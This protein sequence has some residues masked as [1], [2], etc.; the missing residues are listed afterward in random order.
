[1]ATIQLIMRMRRSLKDDDKR[2]LVQSTVS[3]DIKAVKE[4]SQ[5]FV[6]D[7]A[8]SDLAKSDLAYYYKQCING[9]EKVRKEH[10]ERENNE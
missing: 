5:Q 10:G 7:L 8:K 9:I 2:D 6:F 1:M 3:R 4:M